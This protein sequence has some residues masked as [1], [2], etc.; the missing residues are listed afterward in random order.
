MLFISLIGQKGIIHNIRDNIIDLI[1]VY[2]VISQAIIIVACHD[3]GSPLQ[4]FDAK[5]FEDVI[6]V[7][8][9]SA[10]LKLIQGMLL[11]IVITICYSI[12]LI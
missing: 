10:F 7:F 11:M 9:T 5:V 6:S 2:S 8:I 1:H 4:L 12:Q 3:P